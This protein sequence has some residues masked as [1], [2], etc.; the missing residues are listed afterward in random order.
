[1]PPHA[2]E[3]L[4][5][6]KRFGSVV[7]ND[8]VT[9]SASP[10]EVHALVGENGA[11]KSTLMSILAGMYRPD[12]G[13]FRIDGIPVQFQSPRDAIEH[14]IGMV[15]QHFMLVDSF[16]VAENVLLG[17]S[18][19][20]MRLDTQRIQ[21]ELIELSKRYDLQID[22]RAYIWQ[23][24][25]GEQQRVEI[26]RLLH[27]GART[28]VFDE[29]TA[30]LT[31][32][33][34]QSLVSHLRQLAAQGFAV[35]FISH[36]LDEVLEVADRITVLRRGAVV[37]TVDRGELTRVELAR[38]M[39]GR[40]LAAALLRDQ[41]AEPHAVGAPTLKLEG[42]TAQGDKSLP[43]LNGVSLEVRSGG[44]LGIAGVAGNGQRELAEVITGLRPA[45]G[46]TIR[47]RDQDIT[48]RPP[49]QITRAG[50]A[51]IPEDRLGTGLA[52]GLDL[53]HNAIMRRYRRPP[54]SRGPFLVRRA[55]ASFTD[56]LL[57]RYDVKAS[58]RRAR[59]RD[60][61]GGNQQKL[62]IA[63]ELAGEPQA[64]VAVH[65]TRGVDVG[66]SEAIHEVLWQQR[67]RGAATLLISEDLDELLQ[68][69][70]RVA[71]MFEGRILGTVNARGADIEQI[72]L[73][74]SGVRPEAAAS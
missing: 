4:D 71:V 52:G 3:M 60:L 35:I 69:S 9:F 65:P 8:R 74:M 11:G 14:G 33:E 34:S 1:M 31:P 19:G 6:T 12:S 73:L 45:I 21:R 36:K 64:I 25:V 39:V 56:G 15:Y 53:S 68:L 37:G 72:G 10:G 47:L 32:Q 49:R 13:E 18:P 50:V 54:L 62:L 38:M 22:P 16:T 63:R 61:S 43:A 59:L 20:G 24:S 7:A 26:I 30:V 48:N 28:L 2:V 5:I 58:G 44:T 41:E 51:H 17:Q 23:L 29:P 70:D 55:I 40:E 46:G 42:V 67:R 57:Q 66:A 27:R